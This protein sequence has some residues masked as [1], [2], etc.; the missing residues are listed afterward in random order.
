MHG[1]SPMRAKRAATLVQ[2]DSGGIGPGHGGQ[3]EDGGRQDQPRQRL[4]AEDRDDQGHKAEGEASVTC[5][6]SLAPMVTV[7]LEAALATLALLVA[8][9]RSPAA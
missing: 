9:A 5:V 1:S 2:G 6:D 7:A 3:D 8:S 4:M